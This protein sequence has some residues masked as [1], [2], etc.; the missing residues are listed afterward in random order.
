[1]KTI[2]RPTLRVIDH[3]NMEEKFLTIR[4]VNHV[5]YVSFNMVI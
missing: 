3:K 1:M 2:K 5:K 4:G